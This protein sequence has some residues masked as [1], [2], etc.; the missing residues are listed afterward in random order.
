MSENQ[1]LT[2]VVPVQLEYLKRYLDSL[3]VHLPMNRSSQQHRP[4]HRYQ[5]NVDVVNLVQ[6][7]I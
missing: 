6:D 5:R 1:D 7:S 2:L 3:V 4:Y